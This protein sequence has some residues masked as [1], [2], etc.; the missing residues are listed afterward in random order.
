MSGSR[1]FLKFSKHDQNDGHTVYKIIATEN[2]DTWELQ[3]RYKKLRE[4]YKE[5]KLKYGKET[6]PRFPPKKYFGA[7]NDTFV[8]QR[9][10]G[11]EDFFNNVLKHYSLEDVGSLKRFLMEG[12]KNAKKITAQLDQSADR[13]KNIQINGQNNDRKPIPPKNND[14]EK[15]I[16]NIKNQFF[17]L[18]DKYEPK[19]DYDIAKKKNIY[20]LQFKL[21]E[22]SLTYNLPKGTESNLIYV[23]DTTF[24][25]QNGQVSTLYLSALD[26]IHEAITNLKFFEGDIVVVP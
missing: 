10:K 1:I 16:T 21:E 7:Q 17:D 18:S 20:N 22:P 13:N 24:T 19:D 5:L 8:L 6:L 25:T 3:A 14:I 9:Q 15:V 11:L 4:L 12:K 26:N 2:N 23:H